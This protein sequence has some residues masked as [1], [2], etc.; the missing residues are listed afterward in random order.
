[1][2]L[3]VSDPAIEDLK[4][5]VETLKAENTALK[6]DRETVGFR[7]RDEAQ[8][9]EWCDEYNDFVKDVNQSCS[10]PWL[11]AISCDGDDE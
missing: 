6:R 8:A 3:P 1:M 2:A 9:R 5:E 7:L 10:T 11:E 4:R